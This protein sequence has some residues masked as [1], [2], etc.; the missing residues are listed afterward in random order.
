LWR[1]HW[2]GKALGRH[3][4]S[5][6][7]YGIRTARHWAAW[8][9]SGM[10]LGRH[11]IALGRHGTGAAAVPVPCHPYPML[12]TNGMPSQCHAASVP[13]QCY[14]MLCRPNGMPS[15]CHAVPCCPNDMPPK[16]NAA[17]YHSMPS[18]Q[19]HPMAFFVFSPRSCHQC[20]CRVCECT[21]VGQQGIVLE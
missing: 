1:W 15:H 16:C 6:G 14:P 13:F 21:S 4:I 12:P 18:S 10:T 11:G 3:G 8:H 19:C 9:W 20:D 7:Q 17:P 2:G 5:L